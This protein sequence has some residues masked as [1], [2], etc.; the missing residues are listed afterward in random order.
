MQWNYL[1]VFICVS[2][3]N[4]YNRKW[5][6]YICVKMDVANWQQCEY[7]SHTVFAHSCSRQNSK[8]RK[9][10]RRFGIQKHVKQILRNRNRNYRQ[11]CTRMIISRLKCKRA[12]IECQ[13][14]LRKA[15]ESVCHCMW[16]EDAFG[17][18]WFGSH[19]EKR[20]K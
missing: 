15:F 11:T 17:L 18:S 3:V 14:C 8:E 13:N 20:I 5:G 10:L 2:D 16:E 6:K 12:W 4:S 19:H 1:F 9:S 7:F